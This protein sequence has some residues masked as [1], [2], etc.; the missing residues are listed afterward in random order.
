EQAVAE[1]PI[2]A[3]SALAMPGDCDRCLEAGADA[4]LSKP[5]VLRQLVQE[6]ETQLQAS[7]RRPNGRAI[8]CGA[9]GGQT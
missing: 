9:G 1:T 2:I 5:L 6:I 3:V 8:E 4:Y 7:R